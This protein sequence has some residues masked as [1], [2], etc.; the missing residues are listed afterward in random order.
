MA[1]NMYKNKTIVGFKYSVPDR[2]FTNLT[3]KMLPIVPM[4][5]PATNQQHQLNICYVDLDATA[6]ELL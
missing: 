1:H 6:V 5:G 4:L 2:L 3:Y